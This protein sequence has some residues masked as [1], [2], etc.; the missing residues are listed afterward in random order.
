MRYQSPPSRTVAGGTA[1]IADSKR[2]CWP[3]AD[4]CTAEAAAE[5]TGR[6]DG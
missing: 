4:S 1:A 3:G 5:A 6:G 2:Q